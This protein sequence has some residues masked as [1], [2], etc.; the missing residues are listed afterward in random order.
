MSSNRPV[1]VCRLPNSDVRYHELCHG[2]APSSRAR[3]AKPALSPSDIPAGPKAAIA[4]T[5]SERGVRLGAGLG[6]K[7]WCDAI[8]AAIGDAAIGDAGDSGAADIAAAAGGV[9]AGEVGPD[10]LATPPDPTLPE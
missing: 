3:D 8:G 4:L 7:P 2:C 10:A 6:N 1:P 5:A 9:A